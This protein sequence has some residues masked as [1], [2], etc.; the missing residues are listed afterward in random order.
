[1]TD[2]ILFA[3]NA[4][5]QL[6]GAINNLTLSIP[7]DN[8]S[9]FPSPGTGEYCLATIDDGNGTVEIVKV[10][11]RS[12]NTLT[13]ASGGRGWE[14]TTASG[15]VAGA[16]V[17]LRLTRDTMYEF[18]QGV[19]NG[20]NVTGADAIKIQPSRSVDTEVPSGADAICIGADTEASADNGIAIGDSAKAR[21]A[22][23][24]NIGATGIIKKDS[25][26]TDYM[27]AFSGME[28][29]IMT[30][31]IDLTTFANPAVTI[32]FAAGCKFFADECGI[33]M[34]V[35]DTR[36]ADPNIAM[37]WTGNTT[38]LVASTVVTL[39][40]PGERS[41]YTASDVH[42]HTSLTAS[43]TTAGT[44]VSLLGRMY[45]KGILVEDE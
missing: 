40:T 33:I 21:I 6:S 13:V 10:E 45:W 2:K 7:L 18:V 29:I 20:G 3:N 15:F 19:D 26:E 5:S 34:T 35:E 23:T 14:G 27:V 22:K 38:G 44:A 28:T 1:M 37:G 16:T 36:T 39:T 25:G 42:G 24:I 4:R 43:V 31:E 12:G 32:T 41:K 30:P 8:G 11:A 17:A 9:A